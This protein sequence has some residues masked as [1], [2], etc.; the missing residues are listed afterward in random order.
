MCTGL[1]RLYSRADEQS[2]HFCPLCTPAPRRYLRSDEFLVLRCADPLAHPRP[3]VCMRTY[4]PLACLCLRHFITTLFIPHLLSRGPPPSRSPWRKP[5]S[6][7]GSDISISRRYDFRV[8]AC[9]CSH[10]CT[11]RSAWSVCVCHRALQRAL[12]GRCPG[13]F[14]RVLWT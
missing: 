10:E 9:C 8:L 13:H 1:P 12:Y 5:T 7:G 6:V 3:C 14:S 2:G 11:R 4:S